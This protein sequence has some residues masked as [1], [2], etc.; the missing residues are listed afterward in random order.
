MP[1]LRSKIQFFLQIL[2]HILQLFPASVHGQVV[3]TPL[4]P[5]PG[6]QQQGTDLIKSFFLLY[7][8]QK[9]L[10]YFTGLTSTDYLW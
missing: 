10:F 3:S 8:G 9:L 2:P 4:H 1:V 5:H 7:V 6:L